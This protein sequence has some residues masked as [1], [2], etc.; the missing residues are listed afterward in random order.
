MKM[1]PRV[2]A[3]F[4]LAACA[5]APVVHAQTPSGDA[6]D[7]LGELVVQALPMGEVF[8]G[9]VD[10]DP[11]WPMGQKADRVAPAQLQCLRDR[12]STNGYREKRMAE[13]QAFVRRY[14][15]KVDDSLRVLRDGGAALFGASIRAGV[16]QERTGQKVDFNAVAAAFTPG[17]LAA[18]IEL[19]SDDKHKALRELIG[20]DDAINVQNTPEQNKSGGRNKGMMLGMKLMLSAMDYCKVPLAAVQ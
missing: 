13:S 19:T 7:Q 3:L 18:F 9:F 8:Q 20:I 10:K 11:R 2:A 6:A 15:D 1:L 16:D 4:L 12:L 17:Q 5:F 14:P